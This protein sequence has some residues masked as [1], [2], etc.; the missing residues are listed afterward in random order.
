MEDYLGMIKLNAGAVIPN[1]WMSCDGSILNIY[2]YQALFSILSNFYG[3]DGRTTFAL[4]DLRGRAAIGQ[5]FKEYPWQ[6]GFK[7]GKENVSLSIDQLPS[8][9]HDFLVSPIDATVSDPTM[10][11]IAASNHAV[12]RTLAPTNGYVNEVA[13]GQLGENAIGIEGKGEAHYNMQPFLALQ[14]IICVY[15]PYP[16]RSEQT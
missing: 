14:F 12:G 5:D 7:G 6:I 9:R 4:P 13:K 11:A 2:S 1:G 15:G 16:I 3:G 8:H 10:A